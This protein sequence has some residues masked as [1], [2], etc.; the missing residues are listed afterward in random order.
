MGGKG[1]IMAHLLP[2]EGRKIKNA[3]RLTYHG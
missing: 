2:R 3:E 1:G